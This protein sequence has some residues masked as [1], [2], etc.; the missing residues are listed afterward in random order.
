[1]QILLANAKIMLNHSMRRPLTQPR[2][3]VVAQ[4]IASELAQLDI[5]EMS[6]QL[7]CSRKIAAENCLRFR[8]FPFAEKMPAIMAYYGQSYKHLQADTLD[9]QALNFAQRHLWITRFLYGLL[10]PMD[11]IAPY[12][13]EHSLTLQATHDTPLSQYW[14]D[15]LTDVLIDSVKADDGTLVHL[16]T[17]EFEHLFNWKRVC[18]EVRVIQPLFYV[19]DRLKESVQAVWAKTGRGALTRYILEHQLKNPEEIKNFT[20]EGFHF[21][22][23]SGRFVREI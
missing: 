6:R 1:M 19:R 16:S 18:R 21:E 4:N 3:Q 14:R 13:I 20:Y 12:R 22:D 8:N 7:R 15:L 5:D 11:G 17:K 23:S 10:R 9:V 2:F